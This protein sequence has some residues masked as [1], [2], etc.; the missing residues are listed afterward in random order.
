MRVTTFVL[1]DHQPPIECTISI[2]PGDTGGVR[3]NLT[4]WLRQLGLPTDDAT[5]DG[6]VAALVPVKTVGGWD[7]SLVDFRALAKE[8]DVPKSLLGAIVPLEGQTLFV[9][10]S[11]PLAVLDGEIDRVRAL[12]E[13]LAPG[14][15]P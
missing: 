6:V 13:S 11:A 14:G 2:F 3:A 15:Q 5:V 9:K 4:R 8:K 10:L 12:I 7:A 1:G